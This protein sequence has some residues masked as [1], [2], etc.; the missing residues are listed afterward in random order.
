MTEQAQVWG[1]AGSAESSMGLPI[2]HH[3]PHWS[4][5][6]PTNLWCGRTKDLYRRRHGTARDVT[7]MQ[8]KANEFR[9]V[10]ADSM[11]CTASDISYSAR[12][13]G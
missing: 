10:R 5:I 3:P 2:H 7:G 13:D 4:G 8:K 11:N 9:P 12:L 1:T 6:P